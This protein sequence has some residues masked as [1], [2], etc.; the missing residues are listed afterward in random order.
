MKK[1]IL[2]TLIALSLTALPDTLPA[3]NVKTA[4]LKVEGMTCW[5][6]PRAVK[7][8]ILRVDGV[9]TVHVEYDKE[10]AIDRVYCIGLHR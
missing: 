2:L 4:T 7:K 6:C 3:G 5:L 8:V 10:K 9:K 1:I